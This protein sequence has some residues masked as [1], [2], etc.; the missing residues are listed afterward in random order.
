MYPRAQK[1][2][3]LSDLLTYSSNNDEDW[4]PKEIPGGLPKA[5][6]CDDEIQK[7]WII[8]FD[9]LS[10]SNGGGARIVLTNPEGK[11]HTQAYKLS[12]DCTKMRLNMRHLFWV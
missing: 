12:F 1:S 5:M 3:A 7:K 9:G 4:T 6:V 2:Q 10:T 11:N 8:T